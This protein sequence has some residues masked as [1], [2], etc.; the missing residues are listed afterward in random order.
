MPSQ[1]WRLSIAALPL[2]LAC[3]HDRGDPLDID[4]DGLEVPVG[5][6][7]QEWLAAGGYQDLPGESQI[8]ESSGPHGRVRSFLS[9][10]LEES[11]AA[12]GEHPRGVASIKELYDG[13]RLN[14][15]AVS[16]KIDDDSAD[17]EGW[18]WYEVF[19]TAPDAT[20]WVDGTGADHCADCHGSGR[21]YIRLPYPLE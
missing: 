7:L 19:D 10:G 9:V 13:D 5:A 8:H 4:V 17:G 20:P 18:Y 12:G 1:R 16:V 11:L 3:S 15:W 14:G 6:E 21:D 2:F